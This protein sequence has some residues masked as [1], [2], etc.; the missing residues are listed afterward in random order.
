MEQQ[1]LQ[2]Q[3]RR[4]DPMQMLSPQLLKAFRKA[5]RDFEWPVLGTLALLA[6][7]LGFLGYKAQ[8]DGTELASS[9]WHLL[10][11]DLQLFVIQMPDIQAPLHP[12]LNVARFLAPAVAGYTAWQAITELFSE[13][14]ESCKR[15]FLRGHIVICGLGRKG[16]VLAREFLRRGESVVIIEQD[17]ENDLVRQAR[18]LGAFVILGDASEPE[19]LRSGG[20]ARARHL[21][22]L[23]GDDGVNAEIAVHAADIVT[24]RD[25]APL[26]CIVHIFDPQLCS[27]LHERELETHSGK[28]IRI[29][30]FNVF[31]LGARVLLEEELS[32]VAPADQSQPSRDCM[33]VIGVG[34]LGESL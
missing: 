25:G 21:F 12:A 23:C 24:A 17:Q 30:F 29:E 27:L 32:T 8:L 13:Q 2:G 28:R 18:E 4:A 6:L 7:L 10:Y 22:A 19:S 5:W 26:T 11:L 33:I 34:H 31:E 1:R 15:R 14:L 3:G 16:L 20:V 9:F